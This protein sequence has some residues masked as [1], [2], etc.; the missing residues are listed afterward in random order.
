M[1]PSVTITSVSLLEGD[2]GA[3]PAWFTVQ[4]SEATTQPVAV[5]YRTI[6][7]TALDGSD[8]RATSG[9]MS[10]APGETTKGIGVDILGDTRVEPDEVLG[11]VLSAPQNAVLARPWIAT[12]TI[13]DDDRV[14]RSDRIRPTLSLSSKS[15]RDRTA[16]YSFRFRG[17]VRVPKGTSKSAA[18]RAG[19]VS[20]SVKRWNR[21]S[22]KT[23]S[24]RVGSTCRYSVTA[25]L[26]KS[27]RRGALRVRARFLGTSRLAAVSSTTRRFR[28]G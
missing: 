3:S 15:Y 18:C 8:Y 9:V 5:S 25:R 28:A 27:T 23:F 7:D 22:V 26:P 2:T 24:A 19:R 17:T 21:R 14:T 6:D 10:F 4:L 1:V 20:I 16:P 13:T 11:V 12:A